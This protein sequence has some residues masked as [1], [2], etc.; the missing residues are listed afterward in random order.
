LSESVTAFFE[1]ANR[2]PGQTSI[3]T[4]AGTYTHVLPEMQRQVDEEKDC[5]P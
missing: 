4:T 3:V 2:G 1:V 5:N